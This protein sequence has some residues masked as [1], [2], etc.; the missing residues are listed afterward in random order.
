MR[1]SRG[2]TLGELVAIV[3]ILGILTCVAVP[4]LSFGILGGRQ[5]ELEARKLVTDLRRA[6]S[7]AILHAATHPKGFALEIRR[8]GGNTVC[9]ILDVD[10]SEVVDSR[11]MATEVRC[12]GATRFWFSGL[13]SLKDCGRTSLKLS[14]ADRAFRITVVPSTGAVRCEEK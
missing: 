4:R 8:E 6:R 14:D 9:A 7:L 5:S 13:G 3:L 12:S 10:R 2:Y 1:T 11:P